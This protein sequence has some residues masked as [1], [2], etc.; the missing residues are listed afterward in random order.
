MAT[1]RKAET[2]R[3]RMR[4]KLQAKH[5]TPGPPKYVPSSVLQRSLLDKP[6]TGPSKPR[7]AD[8]VG[9]QNVANVLSRCKVS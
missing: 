7:K 3:A 4:G 9:P 5:L 1:L 6:L 8:T 2:V